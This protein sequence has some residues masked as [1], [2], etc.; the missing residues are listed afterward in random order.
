V[1][2]LVLGCAAIAKREE[3]GELGCFFFCVEFF[4]VILDEFWLNYS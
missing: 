1:T 2:G 4:M 3:N